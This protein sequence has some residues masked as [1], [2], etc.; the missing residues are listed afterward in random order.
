MTTAFMNSKQCIPSTFHGKWKLPERNE[1]MRRLGPEFQERMGTL[2][3]NEHKPSKLELYYEPSFGSGSRTFCHYDVIWGKD[4]NGYDFTLF[5]VNAVDLM[6]DNKDVDF[7]KMEFTVEYVLLGRHV[8]SIHEPIFDICTVKFPYLKHWVFQDNRKVDIHG[9]SICCIVDLSKG[10]PFM[11]TEIEDGINISLLP[12]SEYIPGRYDT[13]I[14]QNTYLH[15]TCAKP[16]PTSRFMNLICEFSQFLSIALFSNQSPCKI[17]LRISK[18]PRRWSF[19]LY[20]IE[21]STEPYPIPLIK[22]DTLTPKISSML[23]AWHANF[24]QLSP[25]CNY[26]IRSLP[27][28]RFFDAPDFLIIAQAL[29]GYYKRFVNNKDG[30]NIKQYQQQIRKLLQQFGGVH[31]LQECRIDADELTQS[32]HKY[33][34]LIPDDDRKLTKAVAGD[35]LYDLTQKCIVLLTCCILDNIGLTTEEINICFED[36][37]IRQIV[38]KLP[39]FDD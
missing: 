9:K 12:Y 34:H 11:K 3:Y 32:R 25:I 28:N 18:E 13:T 15:I 33:S 36:S 5:N 6:H 1:L 8:E 16:I 31:M 4:A 19:L 37:A 17:E 39:L 21:A 14:T 30:K 27:S 22:Y 2:Y 10:A 23:C 38:D 35:E 29:D 20:E 7:S 26:L 24:E